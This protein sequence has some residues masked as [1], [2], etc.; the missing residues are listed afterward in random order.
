MLFLDDDVLISPFAPDLFSAVP[1]TSVGAIVEVAHKQGW[2]TMH[3][4]AMCSLYNL[5]DDACG[6]AA[7]GAARIFNSGVM[8]LSSAHRPLVEGWKTEKL[9]CKIL[10]DQLYLN[11]MVRRHEVCLQDLGG[12]FNMPGTQVR[13]FIVSTAQQRAAMGARAQLG[14]VR[15][16]RRE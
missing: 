11:A 4:R 8:L 1:C 12:G 14:L 6:K 7:L 15:L 2:H 10:C 5:G 9:E 3:A 16:Q 13:K